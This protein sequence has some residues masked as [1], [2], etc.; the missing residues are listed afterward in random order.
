[1]ANSKI[2]IYD[3]SFNGFLTAV[4]IAFEENIQVSDIQKNSIRQNRL[5]SDTKTIFTQMNKAKRVWNAIDAKSNSVIKNIY[6]TY[7]SESKNI[8]LLLYRY[9]RSLF[10]SK[11]SNLSDDSNGMLLKIRQLANGVAKE[12]HRAEI[13][14]QFRSTNDGVLFANIDPDSDL[15]PLVSKH[16]RSRYADREWLV[17]DEK[18]RYGIYYDLKKVEIVSLDLK[19]VQTD[20]LVKNKKNKEGALSHQD[21]W[22]ELI[23]RIDIKSRINKKL[24]TPP[25]PKQH[26]SFA[27]EKEAV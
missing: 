21:L 12:K 1:M 7:L 15:L 19:E 27:N 16:F 22:N 13:F 9:I 6:F 24:H 5:F 14:L 25:L 20:S 18:R 3:G 11:Y 4:F 2:L 26:F 23:E 8:E 17:Y 10:D